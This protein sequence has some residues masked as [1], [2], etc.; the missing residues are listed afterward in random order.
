MQSHRQFRDGPEGLVRRESQAVPG[1]EFALDHSAG[2][3]AQQLRNGDET[4]T[5]GR[6]LLAG[7]IVRVQS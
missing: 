1:L 6:T 3:F 2:P 5:H 4:I 7:Q